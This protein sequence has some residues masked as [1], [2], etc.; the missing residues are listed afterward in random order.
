MRGYELYK[1]LQL[2]VMPCELDEKYIIGFIYC[3]LYHPCDDD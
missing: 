1:K 2:N 3:R